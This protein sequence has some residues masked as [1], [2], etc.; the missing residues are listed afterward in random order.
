M[1]FNETNTISFELT[2]LLQKRMRFIAILQQI[3]G[4]FTVISGGLSCLGIITAIFGIPMI[5]AGIRLFQSGSSFAITA[6][7]KKGEYLA[8]AINKLHSYW[9]M[10]LITFILSIIIT[11]IVLIIFFTFIAYNYSYY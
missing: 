6:D 11:A 1:S 7:V 10:V 9:M 2:E 3:V 5:I 4:V 8:D